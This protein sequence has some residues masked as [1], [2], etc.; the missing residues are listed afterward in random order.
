M[1]A[2]SITKIVTETTEIN[3]TMD[4][5]T[6]VGGLI[7]RAIADAIITG[8]ELLS[9]TIEFT[10]VEWDELKSTIHVDAAARDRYAAAG[11]P[12]R[13][14]THNKKKAA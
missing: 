7:D 2:L 10:G 9:T 3:L 8:E 14:A 11:N 13:V 4:S 1:P 12:T 5:G 6:T